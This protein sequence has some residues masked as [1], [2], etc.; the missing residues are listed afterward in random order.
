MNKFLESVWQFNK[1]GDTPVDDSF[2]NLEAAYNIIA[3][4]LEE[5]RVNLNEYERVSKIDNSKRKEKLKAKM[6][7]D[8][9]DIAVTTAGYGYRM[10][11]PRT[12]LECAELVVCEANLSKFPETIEEA[13]ESVVQYQSDSRYE[14]VSYKQVDDDCFVV[15]GNIAGTDHYKI[16]KGVGFTDPQKKLNDLMK[17]K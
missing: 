5:L 11:L 15:Y 16:L 3:S 2:E 8:L 17:I 1:H 10:G 6:L 4:E 9:C 12:V 14:N 7:D 13:C